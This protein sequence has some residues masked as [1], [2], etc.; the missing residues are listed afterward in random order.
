MLY[1]NL[2]TV[3]PGDLKFEQVSID[4]ANHWVLRFTNSVENVGQIPLDLYGY[5]IKT[6]SGERKTRVYQLVSNGRNKHD[7]YRAGL[8]EFHRAHNHFHFGS[9]ARYELWTREQYDQWVQSGRSEGEEDPNRISRKTTFC[10]MDTFRLEPPLPGSPG[11]PVYATC[12]RYQ[13]GLSVGWADMYIADLPD[14][15]IDLGDNLP[16]AGSYVL[17]SVADPDN[18]LYESPRRSKPKRES[19][20]ANAAVMF[21]NVAVNP[22]TGEKTIEVTDE[23]RSGEAALPA[24][25]DNVAE[26]LERRGY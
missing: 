16:A 15:W 11:E 9:F 26:Q 24:N 18:R 22:E 21:F 1:P 12:G 8:F 6:R 7:M 3:K 2:K 23:P 14:Q 4:G 13:Q 5:T 19:N 17:R 10:V 25:L 20:E